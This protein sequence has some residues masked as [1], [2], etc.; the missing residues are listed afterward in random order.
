MPQPMSLE[1]GTMKLN[2]KD[3]KVGGSAELLLL[4]VLLSRLIRPFAWVS[5]GIY[6]HV[7]MLT[8]H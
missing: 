5:T 8:G 2:L 3:V 1:P 7:T 6:T 4:W